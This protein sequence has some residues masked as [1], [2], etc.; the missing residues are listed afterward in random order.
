MG[1][2]C[3]NL[4]RNK[5][6]T[7]MLWIQLFIGNGN[8]V[9]RRK[10]YLDMCE[11]PF[12][13]IQNYTIME[14]SNNF[15]I[16]G[17]DVSK[18][19]IKNII[20]S[21][22]LEQKVAQLGSVW[23]YELL[24]GLEFSE[25]KAQEKLKFGIGQITRIGGASNLKPEQSVELY[26]KIQ[27]Y[28]LKKTNN[29]V[30]ALVHE[31]ACSGYMARGATLFPQAIGVSS[32]WD[33]D[34]ARSI[35]SIIRE[36]MRSVGA[37]Q[38]LAPLLDITR[39]ARWGRMEE[40]F[41]EDPYL[42]SQLGLHYIRGLQ[43]EE[44]YKRIIATGKHFVGYGL[45]E[46]GMNWAPAH[47]GE[48]EL[49]QYVLRPFE[50]AVKEGKLGSVMPA[51][52]ELDGVPMHAHSYLLKD[53]LRKEWMF[54]GTFV[55]D[56]FA[57]ASLQDY[58]HFAA[59]RKQAAAMALNAGLDV[60]LPN[61]DAFGKPLIEGIV[62]GSIPIQI[63]DDALERILRQ[64]MSIGLFDRP[65]IDSPNTF[66][67]FSKKESEEVSLKASQESIIL[68]KNEKNI[69]PLSKESIKRIAVVGPNAD[70]VRNLLG[71]Y[72]YPCHIE[73]LIDTRE[74]DNAFSQPLPSDITLKDT[75]G[76]HP[77]ILKA[78]I[79]KVGGERVLYEKGCE[80][81][82]SDSDN[83]ENA[84]SAIQR[85]EVAILVLGDKSG[86]TLDCTSG[87]SRDRSSLDLPG[88]QSELVARALRTG[89]P[90]V[91]VLVNGRPVT[92]E[93]MDSVPAIIEAWLPGVKGGEA[94][95]DVLFGDYCPGGKLS[96]SYPYTVGQ[97][98]IYYNHPPS[99]G[100][101][102][103]HG[104]YFDSPSSPRYSFGHGLSYT[105]F[106]FVNGKASLEI[107]YENPDK[108]N[109]LVT[110]S[111]KNDGTI[112]GDEVVQVYIHTDHSKFTTNVKEL[113]AFKRIHINPEETK[114]IKFSIPLDIIAQYE[115]LHRWVV[116]RGK[117]K[118]YIGNSSDSIF[119][120]EE[121]EL[122]NEIVWNSL[123]RFSSTADVMD[124]NHRK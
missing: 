30:P 12:F 107:D 116:D 93:W 119:I 33:T 102:Q 41:G 32:S 110:V 1:K 114:T 90:V 111:I 60:E 75:I 120:E 69:L 73:N 64:K 74:R 31:E 70:N 100:R 63:V 87:E 20:S 29:K 79:S 35:S 59:N 4:E 124:I 52:H 80:V 36:Q 99:G 121:L 19:K 106:S 84:I 85:S 40:T 8:R 122:K 104:D 109:I 18:E 101:S 112:S 24:D 10:L 123:K 21:M 67:V 91:V 13:I 92:G 86:L 96:I 82:K 78:I 62:A 47:L 58:H 54:G 98:P 39:D 115:E 76:D 56:Y 22:S 65:F 42:T 17:T 57:I 11:K 77:S 95:S 26:N 44:P 71:D 16:Y 50:A 94:I 55:S 66:E 28:I 89:V 61:I 38:A 37:H 88:N 97:V 51:Y 118:I 9:R 45:S 23:V 43:F 25:K 103:W 72:A 15:D 83:I 5:E 81:T 6:K 113:K 34:L 117:I 14:S 105:S 7:L 68:L 48:R 27:S 108:S 3:G 46:G 49:M 2:D 53:I